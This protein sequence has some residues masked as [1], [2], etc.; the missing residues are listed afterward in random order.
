MW[1]SEEIN[2]AV[3]DKFQEKNKDNWALPWGE[4]Q[5]LKTGKWRRG[6]AH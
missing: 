1:D 4:Y 6:R 5:C 3:K 2:R